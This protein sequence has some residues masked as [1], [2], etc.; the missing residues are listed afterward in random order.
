MT[1]LTSWLGAVTLLVALNGCAG[2]DFGG[3][4]YGEPGFAGEG[5][6]DGPGIYGPSFG[7]FGGE[8]FGGFGEG[9]GGYGGGFGD[10]DD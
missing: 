7:N 6:D 10:D 1:R 2:G 8:G 9:F 4:G 5:Y 3:Y